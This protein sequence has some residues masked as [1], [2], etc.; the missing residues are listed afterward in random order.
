MNRTVARWSAAL[1]AIT[2]ALA[3]PVAASATVPD[4]VGADTSDFSFDSFTAD[5]YLDVDAAGFATTRVVETLVAEFPDFDQN[6]GIIRAIPTKDGEFPLDV[7]MLSVKDQNGN[8]VYYERQ[9]DYDFADFALGT[10]DFVHGKQTYVLEYTMRNTIRHFADSGGDE[11]Y[12]DINGNGWAQSFGSVT[13]RVHLSDALVGALTGDIACYRGYYGDNEQCE[14]VKSEGGREFDVTAADVGP[15]NTVTVTIGFAGA[16]VVQPALAR[17]SWIVTVAPRVLAGLAGLLVLI[18][19]IVRVAF[20]RDA[21]GRG[22]II[23]QYEVPEGV[24]VL[25]AANIIKRASKGLSAL[26]VDFAVRRMVRVIVDPNTTEASKNRFTLEFLSADGA[27]ND[28]RGVLTA[29]FG[30]ELKVGDKVNPGRLGISAGDKLYSTTA[31]AARRVIATK[32]RAKPSDRLPK[33]LRRIAGWTFLA[34]IPIWVWAIMVNVLDET[35]VVGYTFLTAVLAVAVPIILVRPNLLT[36]AGAEL[37]D[38]LLGMRLYLTV[39]EEDRLRMLQ[40]PD[41]AERVNIN[42]NEAI[43]KIYER[44]LPYAVLWG[45]EDKW[46]EQLRARYPQGSTDWIQGTSFDSNLFS[47]F[48]L[49]ST[50]SVRPIV[51]SS[52]SG[53]S[54]SSSGGSSFS[55]GSSGGGFSGGGGGGGGGG[56]R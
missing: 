44:L 50:S 9:D 3:A 14:L 36:D 49:A 15:Y 34:F 45:V 29:L 21:R 16:T 4:V 47:S 6:R 2:L 18:A 39:A 8:P 26:F 38:H 31:H 12:W 33:I 56:G 48:A 23:A 40:S 43:V 30:S 28:E 53:S 13:A 46:S 10:D 51:T 19:V 37:R 22:T 7:T 1:V 52:S 5:Y 32:L 17:D 25:M 41:G 42:D 55:S 27:T 24:D 20:W 11:F 35:S 54:W